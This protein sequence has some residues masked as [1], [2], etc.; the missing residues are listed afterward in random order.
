MCIW[1]YRSLLRERRRGR[2]QLVLTKRAS[3]FVALQ[4]AHKIMPL[5][6]G[7]KPR[8][9]EALAE[10]ASKR[11]AELWESTLSFLE[12]GKAGRG[13]QLSSGNPDFGGPRQRGSARQR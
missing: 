2:A 9:E 7:N 12:R 13:G 6:G 10:I 3:L 4:D 8:T 5:F 1:P 11:A